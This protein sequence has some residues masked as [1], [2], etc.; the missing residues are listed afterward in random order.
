M[1]KIMVSGY[2]DC[3]HSGH[4]RFF[5][6]ASHFGDLIVSIGCD[7][8][9]RKVKGKEP[10]CKELERLYMVQSCKYVDHAFIIKETDAEGGAVWEVYLKKYKPDYF[11]ANDDTPENW[12]KRQKEV[13]ER[14]GVK[15]LVL[16]RTPPLG[17]LERSSTQLRDLKENGNKKQFTL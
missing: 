11:I 14:N 16:K 15:Y 6:E 13:C 12:Q 17:I 8:R 3:M 4:I 9:L 2:F 1:A 5:Q 10:M 7:E